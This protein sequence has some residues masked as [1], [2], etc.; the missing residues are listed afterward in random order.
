M[1][2]S[3]IPIVFSFTLCIC[4]SGCTSADGKRIVPVIGFA[5][6]EIDDKPDH[7]TVGD[8]L[9]EESTHIKVTGAVIGFH[10]P[11]QGIVLGSYE[12]THTEISPDAN[13]LHEVIVDS[14]GQYHLRVA[15]PQEHRLQN[16]T[17]TEI[18]Q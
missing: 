17:Y 16:D 2:V 18:E 9:I 13:V 5:L 8:G 6:I 4:L 11:I 14:N 3:Y 1:S 12:Q 7:V 15:R 10:P